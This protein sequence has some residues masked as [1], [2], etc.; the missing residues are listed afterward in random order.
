[1]IAE[2]G[3]DGN[4]E[5]IGKPTIKPWRGRI[6]LAACRPAS[7]SSK[8]AGIGPCAADAAGDA[9]VQTPSLNLRYPAGSNG[10]LSFIKNA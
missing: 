1:M 10:Q 3:A 9:C 6:P 4:Q 8:P 5:D 7:I 2:V